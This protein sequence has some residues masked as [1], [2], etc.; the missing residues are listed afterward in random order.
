MSL[1]KSMD[2]LNQRVKEAKEKKEI[3]LQI[4]DELAP[5]PEIIDEI[6]LE[7][8]TSSVLSLNKNRG[9]GRSLVNKAN[10]KLI[11]AEQLGLFTS[12]PIQNK[13]AIPTLLARL[14]IFLPI[15]E[16]KQIALLDKDL[17]FPFET[18]FGRGRRFG[19]PATIEDEDVLIALMRLSEKRVIGHPEKLPIPITNKQWLH[20]EVGELTV[21]VV[22][23]TEAQILKELRITD[24]GKNY[25][26]IRSSL[27]RLNHI[28][29]ELE[30][31]K[32][33]RYFGDSWTGEKIDLIDI[34]WRNFEE[35]GIIF[36][37]FSPVIVRW[38]K[39]HATYFNWEI[40]RKLPS[41]NA[42]ALHRFLST[43]GK[44]YT[45]ELTYIAETIAWD[46]N[47]SRLKPRMEAVLKSLRDD[48]KW[49]D[50]KIKGTGRAKP[51]VLE[52]WR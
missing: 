2:F 7:N 14:P 49:C 39:D 35:D 33:D 45:A 42:R 13:N 15:P 16:D 38:L 30:T 52:F 28:S 24:G 46:G 47:L 41:A 29:I 40:R 32:K 17:S 6:I 8:D 26:K 10:N 23:A 1:D 5:D 36:G 22:M 21:Q 44:Y 11:E 20:N 25:A 37:Q 9:I 18:A 4:H 51:F 3:Q 12:F 27:K 50:Y 34:R 43:Q 19:P 48:H 31:K